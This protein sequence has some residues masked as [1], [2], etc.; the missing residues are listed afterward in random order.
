MAFLCRVASIYIAPGAL[1]VTA[2][3]GDAQQQRPGSLFPITVRRHLHDRN[4][5][6]T[7]PL[8]HPGIS[9]LLPDHSEIQLEVIAANGNSAEMAQ[10]H[11]PPEK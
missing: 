8:E 11:I 9:L 6:I 4:K 1:Q 3:D 2:N 10:R 5:Q 7:C